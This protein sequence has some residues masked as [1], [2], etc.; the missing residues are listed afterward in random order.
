MGD[1][2]CATKQ[3]PMCRREIPGSVSSD[4]YP[5]K[6]GLGY[7]PVGPVISADALIDQSKQ[8]NPTVRV[9]GE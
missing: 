7:L 5:L 4:P 8:K 3:L 9:P 2:R 1:K 6:Q